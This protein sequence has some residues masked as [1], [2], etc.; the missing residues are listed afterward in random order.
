M[1]KILRVLVFGLL[2]SAGVLIAEKDYPGTNL[3][4]KELDNVDETGNCTFGS[5]FC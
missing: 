5:G 3:M 2:F 1:K 4:G